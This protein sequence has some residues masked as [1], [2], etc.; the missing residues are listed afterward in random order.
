[1]LTLDESKRKHQ[2]IAE[3]CQAELNKIS[4][5]IGRLMQQ[6]KK[7]EAEKVKQRTAEL[8]AAIAKEQEELNEAHILINKKLV[9]LPNI[10]HNLVPKGKTAEDNE[11]IFPN[12][13]VRRFHIGIWQPNTIS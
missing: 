7:D 8:K 6:G 10:P 12:W 3:T 5:E 4:K 11:W 1:M 13:A 2:N 9:T